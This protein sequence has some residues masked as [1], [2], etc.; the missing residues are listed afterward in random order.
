M[1]DQPV[2]EDKELQK[3]LENY[4]RSGAIEVIEDNNDPIDEYNFIFKKFPKKGPFIHWEI[5]ANS[6]YYQVQIDY[7]P[8]ESRNFTEQM[9]QKYN[10]SGPVVLYGDLLMQNDYRMDIS[11]LPSVLWHFMP[12]PLC[13][14]VVSAQK[15]WCFTYNMFR[16]LNFGYVPKKLAE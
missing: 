13:L 6:E 3:T 12:I 4:I 9:I 8:E 15:Q 16:H 2:A 10:L 11:L 1:S 14:Y 5:V 7:K